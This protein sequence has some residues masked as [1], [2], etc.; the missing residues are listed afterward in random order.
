[1]YTLCI[2]QSFAFSNQS[3]NPL[4]GP[5]SAASSPAAA[6][7]P[8]AT[9]GHAADVLLASTSPPNFLAD[10]PDASFG[11]ERKRARG[12]V[13]EQCLAKEEEL[14]QRLGAGVE[15]KLGGSSKPLR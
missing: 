3:G 7:S 2:T 6:A 8:P 15:E 1:M 13:L 10:A 4:K 5:S 11:R 14:K 12:S 9:R